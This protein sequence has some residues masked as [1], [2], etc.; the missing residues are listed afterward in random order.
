MATSTAGELA[1]MTRSV[2]LEFSFFLSIPTM[3]AA[4]LY[5]LLKSLRPRAGEPSA[6]GAMPHDA[7]SFIVLAVGFVVSFVVANAVVGWFLGDRKSTRLNSSHSQISYA[8]FCLKKK[9]K[10]IV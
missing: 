10:H 9:K 2:A 5:D 1:G 6:I 7:H 4:T 8:V 3:A